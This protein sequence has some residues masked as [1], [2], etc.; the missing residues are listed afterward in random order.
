VNAAAQVMRYRTG[1]NATQSMIG[2]SEVEGKMLVDYWALWNGLLS[3]SAVWVAEAMK[4]GCL[5]IDS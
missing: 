1:A 5:V 4:L 3:D 2:K